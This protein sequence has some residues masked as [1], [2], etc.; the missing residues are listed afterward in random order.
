M[1]NSK[2]AIERAIKRIE[3]R[4][5]AIERLI[6]KHGEVCLEAPYDWR[7]DQYLNDGQES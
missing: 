4:D 2:D 5:S 7:D 3:E 1:I 6:T